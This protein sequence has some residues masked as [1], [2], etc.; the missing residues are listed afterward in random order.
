[1]HAMLLKLKPSSKLVRIWTQGPSRG[2]PGHPGPEIWCQD[3]SV[4]QPI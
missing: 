3:S 1:M 2:L 4:E